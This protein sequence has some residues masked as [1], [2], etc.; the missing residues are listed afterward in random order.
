M[1]LGSNEKILYFLR[2]NEGNEKKNK[3]MKKYYTF[4]LGI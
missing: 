2:T 1:L 3:E 4:W